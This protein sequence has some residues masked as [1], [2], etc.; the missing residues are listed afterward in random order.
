MPEH[1][2]KESQGSY[3]NLAH[4]GCTDHCRVGGQDWRESLHK[5]LH[6]ELR[7]PLNPQ[8]RLACIDPCCV[9][10]HN[11]LGGPCISI[12]RKSCRASRSTGSLSMPGSLQSKRSRLVGVLAWRE[13]LHIALEPKRLEPKWLWKITYN[14]IVNSIGPRLTKSDLYKSEYSAT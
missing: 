8:A 14:Y 7:G 6:K 10:E 9:G 4:S 1:L 13:L 3:C 11:L 12:S 2:P 5:Y